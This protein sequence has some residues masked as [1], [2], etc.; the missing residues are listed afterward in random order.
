MVERNR[1]EAVR[2]RAGCIGD[3]LP[4]IPDIVQRCVIAPLPR[5]AV[6]C[7]RRKVERDRMGR[8][9]VQRVVERVRVVSKVQAHER[10]ICILRVGA[11]PP[12]PTV[13][14]QAVLLGQRV[15]P[16]VVLIAGVLVFQRTVVLLKPRFHLVI[17]EHFF[18]ITLPRLPLRADFP[19]RIARVLRVTV[20]ESGAAVIRRTAFQRLTV[21]QI[22]KAMP[23]F[24]RNH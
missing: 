17:G 13:R 14:I 24:V 12:N 4:A 1:A 16:P 7:S 3:S 10:L 2:F 6:W 11:F 8:I 19:Q 5:R 9:A 20:A 15:E 22:L 21:C 18:R 23:D